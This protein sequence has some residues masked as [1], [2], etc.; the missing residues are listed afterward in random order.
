[1]RLLSQ[2][3]HQRSQRDAFNIECHRSLRVDSP[4]RELAQVNGEADAAQFFQ[5]T[6]RRDQWKFFDVQLG[7]PVEF[8]FKGGL[9]TRIGL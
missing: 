4:Q 2:L 3:I 9:L 8:L 7:W 5:L 1:M 6:D